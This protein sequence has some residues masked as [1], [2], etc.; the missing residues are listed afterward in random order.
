MF[1][2]VSDK[3]KQ[4][5][6]LVVVLR[7]L[8]KM[9]FIFSIACFEAKRRQKL[10]DLRRSRHLRCNTSVL[11][12]S[13]ERFVKSFRIDKHTFKMILEKVKLHL[14]ASS[15]L[16]HSTQLAAVMRYL[17]TGCHQW[18]VAKD[19]HINVGRSTFGKIIHR[20]IPLMQNLLCGDGISLHM[21][22]HQVQQSHDYFLAKFQLPRIFACVDGT[23]FRILKPVQNHFVF[24]NSKGFYSMN[25]MVLCNYNMEILAIDATHPGSCNDSFIWNYSS[26]KEYLS[27]NFNDKFVL[28]DSGYALETFVLTPY[29]SAEIGTHQHRF[30]VK[31]SEALQIMGRTI[32]ELKSRFRCLQRTLTYQPI[33]CCQIINVCCALHNICRRRNVPIGEN[34]GF[35]DHQDTETTE[36]EFEE[37]EF[38]ETEDT[39]CPLRDEIAL[40]IP[41]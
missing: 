5:T 23:H 1:L 13:D 38:E 9:P 29:K 18:V 35:V 11:S 8:I 19:H 24:Y 39:E 21:D 3:Q 33:F 37:T 26:A 20:F 40:A 17:A 34:I 15:T 6:D 10:R 30:N 31:H 28:A 7:K 2:I 27:K 12:M 22:N 32:G 41:H 25:A 4:L 36:N 14:R 16:S